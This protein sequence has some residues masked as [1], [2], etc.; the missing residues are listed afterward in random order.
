MG[1]E[2]KPASTENPKGP[3]KQ[4]QAHW[5]DAVVFAAAT[6]AA[7]VLNH[8]PAEALELKSTLSWQAGIKQIRASIEKEK[9][10]HSVQYVLFSDGTGKWHPVTKGQWNQVATDADADVHEVSKETKQVVAVYDIHTHPGTSIKRSMGL[11]T[12]PSYMPPS[13]ADIRYAVRAADKFKNSPLNLT[14]H[15][16]LV[17]DLKGAW[18]YRGTK[19]TDYTSPE[20][21]EHIQAVMS[22]YDKKVYLE[23]IKVDIIAELSLVPQPELEHVKSLLPGPTPKA[24]LVEMLY[25]YM[26]ANNN[27]A[28]LALLSEDLQKIVLESRKV[29]KEVVLHNVKQAKIDFQNK[30][31]V[32]N[33]IRLGSQKNYDFKTEYPKVQNAYKMSEFGEL[34]FRSYAEVGKEPPFSGFNSK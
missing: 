14:N 34:H 33:F 19:P 24:N 22:T 32:N 28:A 31:I 25:E 4:K 3:E 11:N 23:K 21:Q 27:D 18:Y 8:A 13:S 16:S 26:F 12:P 7:A 9:I 30:T 2:G 6:S 15:Y 29:Y 5:F 20:E 17:F 1:I 10:E